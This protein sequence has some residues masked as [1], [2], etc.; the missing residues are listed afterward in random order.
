MARI[1]KA[2]HVLEP[3]ARAGVF[4]G[5]TW[6][7]ESGR[8]NLYS[9]VCLLVLLE[10]ICVFIAAYLASLV[11]NQFV[12]AQWASDYAY[13]VS[14]LLIATLVLGISFMLGNFAHIPTK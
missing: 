5:R 12:I 1:P 10:F 7:R 13:R 2:H 9:V 11:Y 14:A 8:K 4:S 3:S 6:S